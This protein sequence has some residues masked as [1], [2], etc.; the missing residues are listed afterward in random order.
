MGVGLVYPLF[1]AMLFDSS[2]SLLPVETS[3][4]MRGLWLGIL[5][6]LM[7]LSTFFSAPVWGALS[8]SKGR[9]KPLFYSICIATVGYGI[10][11]AGVALS[12]LFLLLFSRV[13][14]GIASGN[15]SIVQATIADLSTPEQKAKHYGLYAMALGVGF[16]LGP[17]FGGGL[18]VWSYALPFAFATILV[19]LNGITILFFFRETHH[20]I[21]ECALS[22]K[23]GINHLKKAFQ[24]YGVRTVLFCSFLHQF[25]WSYFFEFMSVYLITHYAFSAGQLGLFYGAAGGFYALSTGLLIR[26]FVGLLKPEMCFFGGNFFTAFTI[27]ALLLIPTVHWL[28][29]L[30]FLSIF[31]AAF[32]GPSSLTIVS[33]SAQ[34]NSQGESLGIL[35]SIN[36]FALVI[37]PL[38]SGSLV[39]NYPTLP[40]WVGGVVMLMAALIGVAVFR[41]RLFR[42]ERT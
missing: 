25:A 35:S 5:I 19:V 17:F 10:A 18:A 42:I 40:L 14:I 38:C 41:G 33:N 30:L 26:P 34:E 27:L 3:Q 16:T 11:L 20:L 37:S 2:L 4:G 39:G 21:Y 22:W 24:L 9:K 23:I 28:W 13:V 6:A 7:P 15:T 36:A 31:F 1:A 12:H 8:D 32:I 29:P